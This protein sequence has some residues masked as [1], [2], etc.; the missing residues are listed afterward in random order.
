MADQRAEGE[1]TGE[2]RNRWYNGNQL[3]FQAE[4]DELEE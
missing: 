2:E 4:D 1:G 3:S